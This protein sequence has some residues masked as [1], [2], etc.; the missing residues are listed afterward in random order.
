[1]GKALQR[2]GW[3]RED[4]VVS[5]KIFW[6][7]TG[8]NDTGLS[9]KHIVEGTNKALRRLGFGIRGFDILPQ[10]RLRNPH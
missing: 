2:A 7:G 4:Y 5:T 1:M 3:K 10:A 9:R 8:P 6:G